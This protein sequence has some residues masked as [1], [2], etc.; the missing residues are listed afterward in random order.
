M[1][2]LLEETPHRVRGL[3]NQLWKILDRT[4]NVYII[5]SVTLYKGSLFI[6]LCEIARQICR[7]CRSNKNFQRIDLQIWCGQNADIAL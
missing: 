7:N 6:P 5:S 4:P 3:V 1:L 2:V